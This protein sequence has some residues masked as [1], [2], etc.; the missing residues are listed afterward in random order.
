MRSRSCA[1]K[2]HCPG[3]QASFTHRAN[4]RKVCKTGACIFIK[5][6]NAYLAAVF[7]GGAIINLLGNISITLWPPN[8]NIFLVPNFIRRIQ[9]NR[10]A[11]SYIRLILDEKVSSLRRMRCA[12]GGI[13]ILDRNSLSP[14][15][16]SLKREPKRRATV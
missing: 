10:R 14:S 3:R 9:Q 2:T 11:D 6:K 13:F 5:N 4:R 15:D 12:A 7:T 16:S 1:Q 8:V